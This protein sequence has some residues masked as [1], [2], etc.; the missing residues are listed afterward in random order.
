M[1]ASAMELYE[2]PDLLGTARSELNERTGGQP[3]RCPIPDEVD[4][5]VPMSVAG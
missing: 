1:A 4:P 5:P 2:H 3:Y